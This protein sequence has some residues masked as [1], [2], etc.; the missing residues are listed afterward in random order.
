MEE[1][2]RRD[3]PQAAEL[4]RNLAN[5]ITLAR[6]MLDEPETYFRISTD[7]FTGTGL[8][9]LGPMPDRTQQQL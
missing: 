9:V 8:V 2:M 1:A 6:R 5:A 7:L 4:H 3:S